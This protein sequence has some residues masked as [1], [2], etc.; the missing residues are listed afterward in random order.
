[1]EAAGDPEELPTVL[2]DIV[3]AAV[4][5]AGVCLLSECLTIEANDTDVEGGEVVNA[6][7]DDTEPAAAAELREAFRDPGC[8]DDG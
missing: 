6:G 7:E 4:A 5:A 3:P 1:M 2:G 8:I